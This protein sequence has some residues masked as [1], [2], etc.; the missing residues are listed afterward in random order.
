MHSWNRQSFP[1]YHCESNMNVESIEIKSTAP[2]VRK[3]GII[4]PVKIGRNS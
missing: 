1:W 4:Q 3:M 2:L